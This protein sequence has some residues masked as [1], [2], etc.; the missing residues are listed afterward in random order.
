MKQ[1]LV[2]REAREMRN[3]YNNSFYG[4]IGETEPKVEESFFETYEICAAFEAAHEKDTENGDIYT[5]DSAFPDNFNHQEFL[6]HQQVDERKIQY[7]GI[8][9][10]SIFARIA[11]MKVIKEVA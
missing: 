7:D 1:N 11:Q 6:F 5:G 10:K 2:L 3:N 8:R 4:K 9:A